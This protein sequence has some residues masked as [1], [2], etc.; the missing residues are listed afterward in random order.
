MWN[1][2]DMLHY[3]LYMFKADFVTLVSLKVPSGGPV[4]S[5]AV[6]NWSSGVNLR[7]VVAHG[8]ADLFL[9]R[10]L[11]RRRAD[12]GVGGLQHLLAAVGVRVVDAAA[13]RVQ[14]PAGHLLHKETC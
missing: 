14:V 1:F 4:R 2:T 9:R 10:R 7:L 6:K 13:H 12:G 8:D 5:Y 3:I 11:R